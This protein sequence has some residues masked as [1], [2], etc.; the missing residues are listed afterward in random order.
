ETDLDV[1]GDIHAKIDRQVRTQV[2]GK[3]VGVGRIQGQFR[4]LRLT[5]RLRPAG[6]IDLE[7][8]PPDQLVCSVPVE[9]LAGRGRIACNIDWDPAFLTGLVC[10]SFQY[11]DTLDGVA[12]PFHARLRG[13]VTLALS[14]SFLVGRTQVVRDR[15]RVPTAPTLTS[16]ARIR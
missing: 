2:L 12:L 11:R 6:N 3:Q 4:V 8:R 13:A 7:L 1:G 10:K 14:D 9:A 16:R 5:G 15:F